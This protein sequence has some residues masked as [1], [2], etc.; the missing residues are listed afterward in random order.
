MNAEIPTLFLRTGYD[1]RKKIRVKKMFR[2]VQMI[3]FIVVNGL[4]SPTI[5]A[6]LQ[7]IT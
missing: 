5:V 3:L 1:K 4:S 7:A 2:N 6:S